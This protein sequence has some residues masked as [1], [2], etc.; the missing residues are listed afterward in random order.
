MD[1]FRFDGEEY[2][3]QVAFSLLSNSLRDVNTMLK[4]RLS[5]LVG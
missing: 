3:I 5:D 1:S 2:G 4:M